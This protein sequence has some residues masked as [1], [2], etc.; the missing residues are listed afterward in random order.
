M[1][2]KGTTTTTNTTDEN[3]DTTCNSGMS[4][5][6]VPDLYHESSY[7]KEKLMDDYCRQVSFNKFYIPSPLKWQF[8]VKFEALPYNNEPKLFRSCQI[9]GYEGHLPD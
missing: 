5:L 3:D 8:D 9:L 6:S 7:G 1:S 2:D 4:S